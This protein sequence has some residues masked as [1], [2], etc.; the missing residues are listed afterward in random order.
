MTTYEAIAIHEKIAAIPPT[1]RTEVI[2]KAQ[3][4]ATG[5]MDANVCLKIFGL[6][7]RIS[8]PKWERFVAWVKTK[9]ATSR[10]ALSCIEDDLENEE[11][12]GGDASAAAVSSVAQAT[13]AA[14]IIDLYRPLLSR[15]LSG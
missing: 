5:F 10:Y 12:T 2:A 8:S 14:A 6:A 7:T 11:A 15:P 3:E 1:S 4:I 13:S 9:G